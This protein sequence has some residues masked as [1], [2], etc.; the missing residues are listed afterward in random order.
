MF[1]QEGFVP[2][3]ARYGLVPYD[4]LGIVAI[5]NQGLEVHEEVGQSLL[6]LFW[7]CVGGSDDVVTSCRDLFPGEILVLANVAGDLGCLDLLEGHDASVG[8]Q[9]A[10]GVVRGCARYL[11]SVSNAFGG[12]IPQLDIFHR[13]DLVYGVSRRRSW[14]QIGY[15]RIGVKVSDDPFPLHRRQWW[16]D[17]G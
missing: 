1:T 8:L 11:A 6:V 17:L 16:F 2:T 10:K 12:E 4:G 14:N 15:R 5:C 3:S 9:E 13:L 7:P